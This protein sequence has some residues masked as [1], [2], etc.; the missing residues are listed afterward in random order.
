[1]SR[2]MVKQRAVFLDRDGTINREVDILRRLDQLNILPGAAQAIRELNRLGYLAIV[3]TNQPVVARGWLTE[4]EIDEIH[5]VLVERLGKK[6]AKLDAI[7][8]C[9]HHP[10]ANL[11]RYRLECRCRKPNIGLVRE[12]IKK[13][14][15]NPRKS[16]MV[17]DSTRDILTGKRVGLKTILVKTGYAG[18]DGKYNAVPDFVAKD[19]R[20]AVR[21]IRRVTLSPK[22]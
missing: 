9:P 11:K 18:K 20:E 21:I 13:F 1:M 17:G 14:K 6:G 12:A 4:K 2:R 10:N 15:I 5:A 7:Y 8:Y 22:S 16:F 3:I 19:L